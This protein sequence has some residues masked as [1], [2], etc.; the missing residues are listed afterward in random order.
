MQ[1]I[2]V[3]IVCERSSV[4]GW[5]SEFILH[6]DFLKNLNLQSLVTHC[7]SVASVIVTPKFCHET[8]IIFMRVDTTNSFTEFTF[9]TILLFLLFFFQGM[10]WER[11]M[12]HWSINFFQ[13]DREQMDYSTPWKRSC[14]LHYI[15]S[16]VTSDF[17]SNE[18]KNC[19][20]MEKNALKLDEKIVIKICNAKG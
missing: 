16:Q 17:L 8:S 4:L 1:A 9:W 20:E 15:E 18:K 14:A 19:P 10:K 3:P 5:T 2:R 12:E 7:P 6:Q 13:P 11:N